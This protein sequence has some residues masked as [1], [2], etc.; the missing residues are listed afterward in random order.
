M[1]EAIELVVA[2]ALPQATTQAL[3]KIGT[4]TNPYA[5][6]AME[7]HLMEVLLPDEQLLFLW[8][9]SNTIVI[10]R[11][12][13]AYRECRVS[14][15]EQAGGHLARR[16]SGGGAVYHD[17]GNLNFSFVSPRGHYDVARN[18]EIIGAAVRSFGIEAKISGRNDIEVDGAKFSGNAFFNTKSTS[19]HHG[20]LM[21]QVDRQKLARY[22]QPDPRKLEARGVASVESRVVN[23][24]DLNSCITV[25]SLSAALVEAFSVHYNTPVSPLSDDRLDE[26]V[27]R[28]KQERFAQDSW[29]LEQGH[30]FTHRFDCRYSWGGV[31]MRFNER[32]GTIH[33]IRVYSDVLNAE[34]ADALA[35]ALEGAVLA[36]PALEER[37]NALVQKE[38]L[39]GAMIEECRADIM[40]GLGAPL[41]R[42]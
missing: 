33:K 41:S 9:N 5:N 32:A 3:V 4:Q 11:N 42:I 38:P 37:L 30:S 15:F 26:H 2:Q 36:P 19:C 40:S 12:Q 24:H 31:D 34:F 18:R 14:E 20:T 17:M 16:L 1:A 39:Y 35:E 8:Q 13:D 23:L 7:H 22:L 29:R 27:L 10:G 21:V 25:E 6:L 28:N